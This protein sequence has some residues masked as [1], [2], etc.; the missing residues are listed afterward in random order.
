MDEVITEKKSHICFKMLSP[1]R[2]LEISHG[3]ITA[4]DTLNYR[5][6]RAATDG[7]FSEKI[8]GPE[9]DYECHCGKYKQKRY[10]GV[11]CDKCGVKVTSSAVR[12][13]RMGHIELGCNV[14]YPQYLYG[15]P[16]ILATVLDIPQSF[17]E[18]IIFQ[19]QYLDVENYWSYENKLQAID[20][21][22]EW[23]VY[24]KHKI[25]VDGIQDILE[26]MDI[27]SEVK[28]IDEQLENCSGYLAQ[29]YLH[30]KEVLEAFL[31]SESKPEW[32]ITNRLLVLPA[33]LRPIIQYGGKIYSSE[34][35]ERYLKIIRR[36]LLY[37]NMYNRGAPSMIINAQRRLIQLAVDALFSLNLDREL[38]KDIP[39]Q[40]LIDRRKK[41]IDKCFEF[42]ASGQVLSNRTVDIDRI[43][44]PYEVFCILFKPHIAQK[45]VENGTAH[46][47]KRAMKYITQRVCE[48]RDVIEELKDEVVLVAINNRFIA[49]KV[50]ITDNKLF[51]VNP[52]IYRF[53]KCD[54]YNDNNIKMSVQI[55]QKS[56]AESLKL[57]GVENQILS[58]IS[59]ELQIK[60]SKQEIKWLVEM[61]K[62]SI[63]R[64]KNVIS[65]GE[66]YCAYENNCLLMT[67]KIY[68]NAQTSNGFSYK[69]ETSLGRIIINEILPQNMGIINRKNFKNKY[70][71]EH[72]YEFNEEQV[73]SVLKNIYYMLGKEA[74]I[75]V[76]RKFTVVYER[77][78]SAVKVNIAAYREANF[79]IKENVLNLYCEEI[80]NLKKISRKMYISEEASELKAVQ[81]YNK[82]SIE[83]LYTRKCLIGR[84]LAQ[85]VYKY[86][87][88][89]AKEG[90][91]ITETL[92]EKFMSNNVEFVYIYNAYIGN[93]GGYS[94]YSAGQMARTNPFKLSVYAIMDAIKEMSTK[95]AKN[96][97]S[98]LFSG[99]NMELNS[100]IAMLLENIRNCEIKSLVNRIWHTGEKTLSL[101]KLS[102]DENIDFKTYLL[103]EILE[104]EN[105]PVSI[106]VID[107]VLKMVNANLNELSDIE[108]IVVPNKN[109]NLQM[110]GE[111]AI[112]GN[113]LKSANSAIISYYGNYGPVTEV[114]D[115]YR[116]KEEES[117]IEE[118][119]VDYL[120][121]DDWLDDFTDDFELY[122]EE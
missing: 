86:M 102:M 35:N 83:Y 84:M 115:V 116:A 106:R 47:V 85:D 18:A 55:S 78:L 63:D 120:E 65:S 30:R 95:G 24:R 58:E 13:T 98:I 8:F 103:S 43:E 15:S 29:P 62:I 71:L 93:N 41:Y 51:G 52:V 54:I 96:F 66:A 50:Q 5:T 69:E 87:D 119:E 12:R 82:D 72:N 59:D 88:L 57:F 49:L 19:N 33:G 9:K 46:N 22:D 34:I 36:S 104:T 37:Q 118:W 113:E 109:S 32:M 48:V 77:Y 92:V 112:K 74:Y 26:K 90:T 67:E 61:S 80:S 70:L 122:D 81:I 1:E 10:K 111:H 38:N 53:L 7:I 45:L 23:W 4:A 64:N 27:T 114:E 2:L 21:E 121:D 108:M 17:L 60:P 73:I 16:S 100:D 117:E 79:L 20:N 44:I 3:E 97:T 42:S 99:M 14:V 101:K 68:I 56:K 40:S 76:L 94:R 28:K 75:N 91:I 110:F 11:V 25:G 89:I 6:L 39:T 31:N 107:I 105:I